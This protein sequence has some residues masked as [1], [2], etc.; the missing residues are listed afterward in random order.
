M[1]KLSRGIS[2]QNV[3]RV[4]KQVYK[5]RDLLFEDASQ[6]SNEVCH[7]T[8]ARMKKDA[9]VKTGKLLASIKATQWRGRIA[10]RISVNV[11]YANYAEY[12]TKPH[13]IRPKHCKALRF[14]WEKVGEVVYRKSVHHPGGT[15]Q[16]FFSANATWGQK[17]LAKRLKRMIRSKTRKR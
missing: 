6:I 5:D 16:H 10:F 8:V 14:Y 3:Q 13:I 15:G 11:P 1:A 4:I 7:E 9:P 17:E 12:G 2:R